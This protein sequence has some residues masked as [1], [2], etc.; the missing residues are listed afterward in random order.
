MLAIGIPALIAYGRL[1]MR[2]GPSDRAILLTLRVAALAIALIAL[3]HPVLVVSE[4][5]PQRNVVGVLV[6]DS[7]SMRIADLDATTRAEAV[8]HLLGGRIAP[9]RRA[10]REVRRAALS[11]LRAMGSACR[12]SRISPTTARARSSARRSR[13][14][15]RN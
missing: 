2:G 12:S 14:R 4:A 13:L 6:D 3:L 9:V 10:G 5:V 8:R 7:R 15:A 11:L 1:R